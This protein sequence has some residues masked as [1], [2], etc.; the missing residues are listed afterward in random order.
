MPVGLLQRTHLLMS[1]LAGVIYPQ[2][3]IPSYR[4]GVAG[5]GLRV[6]VACVIVGKALAS[7][8]AYDMCIIG[9]SFSKAEARRAGLVLTKLFK[10][11]RAAC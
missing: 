2:H 7:R 3:E 1:S 9:C 4:S 8:Q 5:R 10:Q 6:L 11:P